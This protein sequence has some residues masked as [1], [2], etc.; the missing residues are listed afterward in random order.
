MEKQGSVCDTKRGR[1]GDVMVV[2][3][4][5]DGED[6]FAVIAQ[7]GHRDGVQQ[8]GASVDTDSAP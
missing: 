3:G 1:T 8:P 4:E 5:R 2:T 6:L 7:K